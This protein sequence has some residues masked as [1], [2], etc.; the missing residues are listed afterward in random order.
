MALFVITTSDNL[1]LCQKI[2]AISFWSLQVD[3]VRN[4]D[5]ENT[6]FFAFLLFLFFLSL[7][8]IWSS[9]LLYLKTNISRDQKEIDATPS[10]ARTNASYIICLQKFNEQLMTYEVAALVPS[11]DLIP[12]TYYSVK[13]NY[14][15]GLYKPLCA[16]RH[17][18][19]AYSN[20]RNIIKS[21]LCPYFF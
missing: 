8:K 11:T 9:L 2:T 17:T 18:S 12:Y 21:G 15:V 3:P 1:T 20:S 6:P 4:I 7:S 14:C 19:S 16:A 5:Y 10:Y 13:S